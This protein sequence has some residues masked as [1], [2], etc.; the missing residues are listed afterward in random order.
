[1]TETEKE[2]LKAGICKETIVVERIWKKRPGGFVI[3]MSTETKAGELV[4]LEFRRMSCVMDQYVTRV[5]IV[6]IMRGTYTTT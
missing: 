5:K 2:K 6:S 3:K 4:T 1:M